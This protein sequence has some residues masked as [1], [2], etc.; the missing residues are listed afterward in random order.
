MEL[1]YGN[2]LWSAIGAGVRIGVAPTDRWLCC[3]P[4]H[5]IGGLSIVLRC[6]LYRIPIV[7][8]PFDPAGVGAAIERHGVIDRVARAH[9]ARAP[10]GRRRAARRGCAAP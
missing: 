5:H 7:L 8:E 6:A 2:H 9:D 4:L 10:A 3:M 1:T